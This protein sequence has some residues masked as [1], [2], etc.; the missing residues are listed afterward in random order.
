MKNI[1][2]LVLG[3]LMSCIAAIFQIMPVFLTEVFVFITAFSAVPVY[4][5]AHMNP[6]VGLLT[7]AAS[8][9]LVSLFSIHEA[10][11]FL[12]TNGILGFT[13]GFIS[14][15]TKRGSVIV[16]ISALVLT[17][18][19]CVLSFFIGIPVFGISLPGDTVILQIFAILVFT[20]IYSFLF[21]KLCILIV[22]RLK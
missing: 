14:H 12:F 9:F 5:I 1:N 2:V 4:I 11:F 17:C 22:K 10:G 20:L 18:S 19:L 3:G 15:H 6:K 8:F 16:L 13:S 21:Y 7:V